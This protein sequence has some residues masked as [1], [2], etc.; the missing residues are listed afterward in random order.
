MRGLRWH[1]AALARQETIDVARCSCLDHH[2]PL[3]T[4]ETVTD[5]SV[6]MPWHT[7]AGGKAKHLHTQIGTLGDQLTA[8]DRLIAAV[9]GLHRIVLLYPR[10]RRRFRKLRHNLG[11]LLVSW[12]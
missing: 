12:Q 5:L 1:R 9:A 4:N 11:A 7:L 10:Q 3:K 6:V 2:R 8:G